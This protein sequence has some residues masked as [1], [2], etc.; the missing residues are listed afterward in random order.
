MKNG[1]LVLAAFAEHAGSLR[2]PKDGKNDHR[3]PSFGLGGKGQFRVSR[4]ASAGGAGANWTT[5]PRSVAEVLVGCS[6]TEFQ[7]LV[8]MKGKHPRSMP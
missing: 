2:C 1:S 7:A 5:D 6:G 8:R 4:V 3:H